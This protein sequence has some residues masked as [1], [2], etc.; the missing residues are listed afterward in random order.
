VCLPLIVNGTVIGTMDFFATERVALSESRASALRNTAFLA[1]QAVHRIREATKL[2]AAGAEL[3]TSIE[4]AERNVVQ[5]TTVAGE[6]SVVTSQANTVVARLAE[7]SA[8]IGNVVQVI[9]AIA[10]QTNLLALNATI[11]SA[12]A[13]EAGKGFAVVASEVKDLATE[14]GKATEDVG[15][16][17]AAIQT[18][19]E[20]VVESLAAIGTIVGQINETQTMISS[21]LTEQAAVTRDILAS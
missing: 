1:S 9:T 3:V 12:R 14:T 7:S 15:S 17:I 20:N 19:A 6:A 5:A 11:E 8:K 21:V 4:E 10:K 18:D 16:L 13:G 2:S